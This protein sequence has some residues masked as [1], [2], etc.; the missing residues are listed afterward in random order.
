M[1]QTYEVIVVVEVEHPYG[2]LEFGNNIE[3]AI[4]KVLGENRS[5]ISAVM[6]QSCVFTH[7]YGAK[8][9]VAKRKDDSVPHKTENTIVKEDLQLDC[10]IILSNDF[11]MV[12]LE[13][14]G[15]MKCYHCMKRLITGDGY[16]VVPGVSYIMS[17]AKAVVCKTCSEAKNE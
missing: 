3:I 12:L 7:A 1:K 13:D 15:K 14:N 9:I 6:H 10:N 16:V 11:R 5:A 4:S 8:E 17:G 2:A